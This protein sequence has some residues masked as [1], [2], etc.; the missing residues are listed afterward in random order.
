MMSRGPMMTIMQ[1][2]PDDDLMKKVRDLAP[3][4]RPLLQA[5]MTDGR[6]L[7]RA[8]ALM[9]LNP[10]QGRPEHDTHIYQVPDP[11]PEP[12]VMRRPPADPSHEED[13]REAMAAYEEC[14][15]LRPP[16][17]FF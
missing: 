15:P 17:A 11:A 1:P 9:A 13:A 4:R 5:W 14:K 8:Q 6:P 12:I 10:L 16:S 2:M 3:R 7:P